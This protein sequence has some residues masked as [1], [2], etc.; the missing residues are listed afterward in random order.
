M[1]NPFRKTTILSCLLVMAVPVALAAQ[2]GKWWKE[3][4]GG[5]DN[6][7]YVTINQITK[8]NVNQLEVAWTYPTGDNDT[9]NFNPIAVDSIVYVLVRDNSL[10]ALDA[11]TGKEIWVHENLT[12]IARRGINY[13]E[14]RDRKDRRLIFQI[15]NTLQEID[16]RSGKSILDFG[17]QGIVN[18]REELGRD[19]R[20]VYRVQSNNPGKVFE[21]LIILGSVT[22][23]GYYAT[24]GHLRAFDVRTGKLVWT[25][26][27]IPQPG[28][29]GY[30]T[31][32]KDAWKYIGG[33]N[34][35]GEIT[36]DEKRGIAYFP[37][38][39]ATYDYYGADRIGT[40][41]FA[42]C[43]LA[44]DARTGKRLWH[45]QFVHH[46]LLDY[47]GTA[48]PQLL[49]VVRDGKKID[50]V[51]MAT[52]Q[53]FVF[54]L[55]R[56]TGKPV[57]PIQERPTPESDMPGEQSW[58]TQPFPAAPPPFARQKLTAEEINPYILTPEERARWKEAVSNANNRGLF[59]PPAMKETV[60]IPGA[61]GGA[62]WGSTS[63][64]PTD[65]TLYVASFDA[66]SFYKM[67][68]EAPGAAVPPAGTQL[69]LQQP[70]AKTW[71][72]PV[73]GSGGV[74]VGKQLEGRM[75]GGTSGYR[76]MEGPTY[77]DGTDAPKQRYY[78]NYNIIR[79]VT[80]PPWSTLT[81]FDLNKGTIKW[82]VPLGEDVRARA[83]GARNTGTMLEP[84]GIL[85]T[86]TGL[87]FHA[88]RDGRIR[89]YDVADG[90][91]LWSAELPAGSAAIP[92]MYEVDGRAYIV[93]AATAPIPQLGVGE[94]G[95]A[96]GSVAITT[97][98]P[99]GYVAFALPA[100]ARPAGSRR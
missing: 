54:T 89:A 12:G 83:E 26:H 36:V 13:W 53:G 67:S 32:P 60:A 78:T 57:F 90:T 65:G 98:A 66:P 10:V 50:A 70:L 73:A 74:A 55:D 6:S 93:V 17:D 7:H 3:Y 24:P 71:T 94:T 95:V 11:R 79:H 46:D 2:N 63:A 76:A 75:P 38:G 25:F 80:S 48:A 33:V 22:G 58:P 19:P 81:A 59:T 29:Y 43:L 8:S 37:T 5:S 21:N 84:K 96:P 4:G 68:L 69:P 87:V 42:N 92:A 62:N 51:A 85:I 15:N 31:W 56:V 14:S 39:S 91:E 82:Q 44:L 34:T 1:T 61:R 52:K 100:K 64:N 30:D 86:P 88:A 27:T 9:Y 99:R 49:T 16:A 35:W 20:T 97:G 23:E 41:L 45:Y 77:P 72:V 47:D 18:L 28:E 40:N